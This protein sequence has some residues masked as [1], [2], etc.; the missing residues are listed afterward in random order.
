MGRQAGRCLCSAQVA[1]LLFLVFRAFQE[2]G[3]LGKQSGKGEG[4]R[5]RNDGL[6]MK[7]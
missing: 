1:V 2:L 5:T 4:D 6:L 3:K 7:F